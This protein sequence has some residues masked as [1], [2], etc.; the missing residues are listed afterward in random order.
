MIKKVITVEIKTNEKHIWASDQDPTASVSC[1][2]YNAQDVASSLRSIFDPMAW[3]NRN[4]SH[5]MCFIRVVD[6]RWIDNRTVTPKLAYKLRC[7]STML[8]IRGQFDLIKLF[9]HQISWISCSQYL[10][11]SFPR[12]QSAWE[13]DFDDWRGRNWRLNST[14][15]FFQI[16]MNSLDSGK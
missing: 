8:S 12:P 6:Q 15:A 16:L 13:W 5:L 4:N 3:L 11:D 9:R 10:I 7:S 14:I 1:V 2:I